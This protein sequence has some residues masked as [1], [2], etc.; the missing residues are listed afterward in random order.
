MNEAKERQAIEILIFAFVLFFR[1]M[2]WLAPV[3]KL[4][5]VT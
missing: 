2:P 3:I 4:R 1:A 5:A